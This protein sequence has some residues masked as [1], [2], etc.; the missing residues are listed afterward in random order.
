MPHLIIPR[1]AIVGELDGSNRDIDGWSIA[2]LVIF[3]LVSEYIHRLTASPADNP[4][5]LVILPLRIPLPFF[6]SGACQRLLVLLGLKH[7]PVLESAKATQSP[8]S[9]ALADAAESPPQSNETIAEPAVITEKV[10]QAKLGHPPPRRWHFS[11]GLNTA[12][13]IGVLLL[14]ATTCIPGSVVRTGI[15]GSSHGVRPYD[16]MTLFI[17]FVSRYILWA[18]DS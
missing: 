14:L 1:T 16:V 6:V 5:I 10:V 2:T 17:C 3:L 4:D 15:V 9:P 8:P 13:V 12:P 18:I 7:R 11:I